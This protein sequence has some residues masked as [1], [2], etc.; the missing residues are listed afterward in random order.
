MSKA[1]QFIHSI[2]RKLLAQEGKGITS[3]AN[4]LQG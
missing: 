4:R 1:L 3:I 2:A